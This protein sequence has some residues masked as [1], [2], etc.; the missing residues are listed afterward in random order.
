MGKK[1]SEIR[2]EK[3]IIRKSL[4]NDDVLNI[5]RI[6]SNRI[7]MM[8]EYIESE[9]ILLYASYKNEIDTKL[10]ANKSFSLNKKLYYPKVFD[11]QMRFYSVDSLS[12][13]N[14]GYMGIYEPTKLDKPFNFNNGLVIVPLSAF[15]R[16]GNR[17]G[18]GGGYYDKFL[19]YYNDLIKVG[20]AYS[21]Q[22]CDYIES[23]ITDVKLDY[24]FKGKTR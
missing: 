18:Y 14:K 10:I 2:K 15:D 22:E 16:N 20:V 6:I 3:L 11:D 9:H 8:K 1:K 7:F 5:S 12:E 13:L 23:E 17:V 4:S 24:I 21:F 19:S